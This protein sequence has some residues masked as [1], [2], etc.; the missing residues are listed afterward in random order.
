[1]FKSENKFIVALSTVIFSFILINQGWIGSFSYLVV[2]IT[3]IFLVTV[4]LINNFY[5]DKEQ[6][7]SAVNYCLEESDFNVIDRV[8]KLREYFS[9]TKD[10][11]A[12]LSTVDSRL[13]TFI[14]NSQNRDM[15]FKGYI[16]GAVT[17]LSIFKQFSGYTYYN[18]DIFSIPQSEKIKTLLSI[19][20]MVSKQIDN[21]SSSIYINVRQINEQIEVSVTNQFKNTLLGDN[22]C[23]KLMDIFSTGEFQLLARA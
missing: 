4:Y 12:Y 19:I 11:V 3:P 1:M 21:G 6:V 16:E 13:L 7:S 23:N 14:F 20:Y 2:I 10:V 8:E 22:F 18:I 15:S 17:C 5:E 9:D